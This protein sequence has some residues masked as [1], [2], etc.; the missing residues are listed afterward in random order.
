MDNVKSIFEALSKLKL[1]VVDEGY[2]VIWADTTKDHP[3]F[4][5]YKVISKPIDGWKYQSNYEQKGCFYIVEEVDG[6]TPDDQRRR[7]V[8]NISSRQ[9]EG[10]WL[11]QKDNDISVIS[12]IIER[13]PIPQQ[14]GRIFGPLRTIEVLPLEDQFKATFSKYSRPIN[15]KDADTEELRRHI[16]PS[17]LPCLDLACNVL[18]TKWHL[19]IESAKEKRDSTPNISDSDL[20]D[21]LGPQ[22]DM[23]INESDVVA[24][25]IE[26]LLLQ[27][28][29]ITNDNPEVDLSNEYRVISVCGL[30]ISSIAHNGRREIFRFQFCSF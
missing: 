2:F 20:K 27:V 26:T 21:A 30:Q 25:Q 16:A 18:A 29:S 1:S 23:L 9:Q 7:L 15:F 4:K 19:M 5:I 17:S 10:F 28:Q 13:F 8:V 14:L 6:S 22:L 24:G 12:S 3:E 11:T